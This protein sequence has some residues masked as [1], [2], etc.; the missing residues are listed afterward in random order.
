MIS[1]LIFGLVPAVR[2]T[3][4]QM[5]TMLRHGGRTATDTPS[6]QRGRQ[7]LVI[8]QTAMAL[9]LL[10]G[11]GLLARSFTRLMSADHGFDAENVLTFRV[12]LEGRLDAPST[13]AGREIPGSEHAVLF[14]SPDVLLAPIADLIFVIGLRMPAASQAPD[15]RMEG[16]YV[17]AAVVG[18]L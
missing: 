6:R 2:Y 11:S 1:A 7:A 14:V 9:V 4:P 16:P 5:L 17:H 15:G 3:R 10:V 12:A 8:V 18:D 13:D